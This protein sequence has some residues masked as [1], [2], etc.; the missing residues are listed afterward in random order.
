MLWGTI[1]ESR[2]GQRILAFRGV[3]HVQPPVGELRFRPPVMA[4]RWEGIKEAKTNGH[5]CA[6]HLAI[7]LDIRGGDEDCLWLTVFTRDLV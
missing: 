3:K 1:E 5:K 2:S 4:P 6:K 7:K